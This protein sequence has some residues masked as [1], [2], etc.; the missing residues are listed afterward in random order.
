MCTR[1]LE[2]FRQVVWFSRAAG[3]RPEGDSFG[4]DGPSIGVAES[5]EMVMSTATRETDR[6]LHRRRPPKRAVRVTCQLGS[7]GLGPNVAVSVVDLSE[8]AARLAVKTT[9]PAGQEVEVNFAEPGLGR[10]IRRMAVVVWC[11]EREDGT[12]SAAVRFDRRLEYS[13]LMRLV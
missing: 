9:M 12:W 10:P 13:D 11:A 6:R 4:G 8:A 5:D 3:D 1:T 7:L 2:E